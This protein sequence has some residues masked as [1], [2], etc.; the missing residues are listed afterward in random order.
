MVTPDLTVIRDYQQWLKSQSTGNSKSLLGIVPGKTATSE[1][2]CGLHPET[3]PGHAKFYWA[4]LLYPVSRVRFWLKAKLLANTV[5]SKT[6]LLTHEV[7]LEYKQ[8]GH[9]GFGLRCRHVQW[10]QYQRAQWSWKNGG[11]QDRTALIGVGSFPKVTL[12]LSSVKHGPGAKF[13]SWGCLSCEL[14]L[15]LAQW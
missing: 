1:H 2:W 5:C 13:S 10:I 12:K 7:M 9:T 6:S 3:C 15:S 4:L 14:A 11:E 8:W